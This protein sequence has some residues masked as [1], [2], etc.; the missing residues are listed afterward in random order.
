M[1][2]Q[3]KY[4][5]ECGPEGVLYTFLCDVEPYD[6]GRTYGPPEKCYPPEGGYATVNEVRNPDGSE[7]PHDSWKAAGIDI[8]K[9]ED[10]AY[11]AW[12]ESQGEDDPPDPRDD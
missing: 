7:L 2:E 9:I 5:V 3:F 4:Q 10:A 6:P 8:K 1:A 12:G 11:E